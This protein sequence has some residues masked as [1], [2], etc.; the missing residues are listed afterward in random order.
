MPDGQTADIDHAQMVQYFMLS[1]QGNRL[2][3][4]L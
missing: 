4:M 3:A 2:D 1:Q